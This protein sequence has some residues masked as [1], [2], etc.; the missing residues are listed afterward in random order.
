MFLD[1]LQFHY[2]RIRRYGIRG[3]AN[4]LIRKSMTGLLAVILFPLSL[5]LYFAGVRRLCIFTDRL[6]HLAMEPDTLLKAQSLGMIKPKRWFILAPS[7]RVAN[8]HLLQYWERYFTIYS[9]SL[10]CFLLNALSLWPFMRDSVSHFINNDK[11]PQL[12]YE[13]NRQWGARPPLL[14]LTAEDC[15]FAETQLLALGLPKGA[16]FVCVHAREGGFSP[17]DEMFHSYRNGSIENLIPSMQE[18][19]KQG[20]WVIR[21]GDPSM[22]KLKSMPQVI[23]YAHHPLRSA[24]LDIILFARARFLLGN[25]SGIYMACSVF[26]VPN[27][28]ANMAPMPVLGV[29][30]ND[31]SIPKLHRNENMAHHL[32][33]KEVMRSSISTFRY[34]ALYSKNKIVVE[35]NSADD[36]LLLTQE[37]LARLDGTFCET[38]E[39]KQLHQAY[40]ALFEPRHY[41]YGSVSK[42]SFSFL[43]RYRHLV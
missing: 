11:G 15:A 17:V 14:K 39:I 28:L 12:V 20:G 19:V 29:D 6:G 33:F 26:G 42:I 41:G 23:D 8:P 7:H 43:E 2:S 3:I 4:K 31:L 10:S 1:K 18:I 36:I 38:A 40:M 32:S 22:T 9:S 25:T 34:S 16:W 24:R 5:I 13:V 30:K 37:M 27:A 35:E 21:V